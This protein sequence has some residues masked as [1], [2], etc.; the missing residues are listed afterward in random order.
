MILL[1]QFAVIETLKMVQKLLNMF[2]ISFTI[3]LYHYWP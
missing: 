1:I 3:F 2:Y